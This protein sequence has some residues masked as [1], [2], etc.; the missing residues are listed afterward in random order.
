MHLHETK[1]CV[2]CSQILLWEWM[3]TC[4][5][6][7]FSKKEYRWVPK[8]HKRMLLNLSFALVQVEWWSVSW[9]FWLRQTTESEPL[10]SS[11]CPKV[12]DHTRGM[13]Q[14]AAFLNFKQF[15]QEPIKSETCTDVRRSVLQS[16]PG[17]ML[18]G[19]DMTCFQYSSATLWPT[20]A[21]TT[22]R[23]EWIRISP[24]K[25]TRIKGQ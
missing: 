12:S 7:H 4:M 22:T 6:D 13:F 10:V 17:N 18:R 19:S 25:T 15:K 9:L 21:I 8:R 23:I 5:F 14:E 24:H 20:I 16:N 2:S 3:H 1:D 11:S